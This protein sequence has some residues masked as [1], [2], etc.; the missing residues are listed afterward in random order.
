MS[1][2]I[3]TFSTGIF[4]TGVRLYEPLFRVIIFQNI[5]QFFGKI[6]EPKL[7]DS[8]SIAELKAQDQAL[9][10]ILTSSLNVELVYVVLKSITSFSA[11]DTLGSGRAPN[12]TDG[13][14]VTTEADQDPIQEIDMKA[15]QN[16]FEIQ[17][18][19][20]CRKK[21]TQI[22]QQIEIK[23]V[24]NFAEKRIS[25]FMHQTDQ[26]MELDDHDPLAGAFGM[27]DD[28][29]SNSTSQDKSTGRLRK[30]SQQVQSV[31][32]EAKAAL[33]LDTGEDINTMTINEEVQVIEWAPAV[34][35]AIKKM[36]GITPEMIE[37]SLSTDANAKQ[38]F[39]AKESAGKSGSFMFSSF[40]K[41]FL[42]KTMNTSE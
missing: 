22:L 37:H 19:A 14:V 29:T 25:E 34:F 31:L 16:K 6:Y 7:K 2:G 33:H 18:T 38:L 40:D 23:M 32:N 10:S 24:D 35:H 9:N 21:R 12:H 27:N 11:T 17:T 4:L 20:E 8:G 1:S 42:I 13:L 28:T 36:D 39:K 41:R 3:M 15:S 30:M 5:Y 26:G